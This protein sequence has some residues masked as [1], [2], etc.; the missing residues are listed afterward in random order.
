[1]PHQMSQQAAVMPQGV[2]LQP[3]VAMQGLQ[4][5]TV[6]SMM[7]TPSRAPQLEM[8]MQCSPMHKILPGQQTL[9]ACFARN[10]ESA[11]CAPGGS[12]GSH[13]GAASDNITAHAAQRINGLGGA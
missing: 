12:P 4:G 3:M 2:F 10:L 11:A 9:Q 7:M 6:P 13:P 8:P 1:M 5:M